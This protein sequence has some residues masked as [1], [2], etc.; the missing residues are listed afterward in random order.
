MSKDAVVRKDHGGYYVYLRWQ[1][2]RHFFSKY[3]GV[4]S[5]RKDKTLAT[6]LANFINSEIDAKIFRP[7]RH[8]KGK[9]LALKN[10]APK[11]LEMVSP[12]LS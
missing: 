11:W 10:Y 5:V 2:Q 1:G 9:P 4:I 3:M 12:G 7:E 8:K 6:Q